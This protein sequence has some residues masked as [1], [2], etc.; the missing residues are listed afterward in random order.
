MTSASSQ[1]TT[2]KPRAPLTDATVFAIA[3]LVDDAGATREP[4]HSDIGFQIE[5]AGLAQADPA[6]ASGPPVGKAKRVRAVLT[7]AL[8]SGPN[9][10]EILCAA[11][12]ALVKSKGGFREG[13]PNFVGREAV[14]NA[15]DAFRGEGYVLGTDGHLRP[16]VLDTLRGAELTDALA[17]CVQR[18]RRGSTDA[19]LLVGTGKDLLEATAAHVLTE[20]F[21]TYSHKDNFPTLLGQAFIALDLATPHTPA[22][23]PESPQR[24]LERALYE[25]GCAVN[26]LR[27]KEGTGHGKPWLPRVSDAEAIQAVQL[28]GIIAGILLT[29]HKKGK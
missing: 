18:A 3:D 19:A 2:P 24:R 28:M 9:K 17:S 12:V 16:V 5:R 22:Q 21:G 27:N 13:S 10:G 20:R 26:A 15:V 4:S 1:T 29:A 8:E 23:Q 7:W 11:L 6:K 25:T 14:A